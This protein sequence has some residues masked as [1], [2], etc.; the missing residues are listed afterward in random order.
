MIAIGLI[1]CAVYVFAMQISQTF[2]A[3]GLLSIDKGL[4]SALLWVGIQPAEFAIWIPNL[5]F[6]GI[7]IWRFSKAPK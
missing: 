6:A 2:A 5:L 4:G 3:T 1:L 7:A